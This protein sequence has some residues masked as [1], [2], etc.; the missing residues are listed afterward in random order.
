M[1]RD[2]KKRS[3]RRKKTEILN[4]RVTIA[5]M[6]LAGHTQ[7]EIA[8]HLH[9]S[10]STISR[11]IT[12]IHKEWQES[13]LLDFN[14]A[15]ARELARID[16]LEREAWIA[17]EESKSAKRRITG[18]MSEGEINKNN[19]RVV[20]ENQNGDPRFL[21]QIERCIKLRIAIFGLETKKIDHTSL[22]EQLRSPV[23]LPAVT[24]I[25]DDDSD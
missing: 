2:V 6:Y 3:G 1:A 23:I 10:Q 8:M 18:H 15:K 5:E 14:D 11:D 19:A 22:G 21:N 24:L 4:D 16:K 20:T 12:I 17:W 13:T 9:L 25:E 7:M